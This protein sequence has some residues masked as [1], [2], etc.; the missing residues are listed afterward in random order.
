MLRWRV[1]SAL[2]GIPAL[3]YIAYLGGIYLAGL[4]GI[5]IFVGINEF[6]RLS[7]AGKLYPHRLV[8]GLGGLSFLIGAY[9]N[10]KGLISGDWLAPLLTAVIFMN[11]ALLVLVFPRYKLADL[12][13]SIFG[14]VYIGWLM[15]HLFLLR[16]LSAQ[17]FDYLLLTLVLTW[18]TD[19][20][21]YFA[22]LALGRHKLARQV[23]PNKTVEGAIGGIAASVLAAAAL[24]YYNPWLPLSL[25]LGLGFVVSVLG[26][27]GDLFES[28]LKRLG[29][30]KDSGQLIPGHGGVLDRFDSL[31]FT[32]PVVYYYLQWF[33]IG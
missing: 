3:L 27:L 19:T 26:Q 4:L 12:A 28:A 14:C 5:L 16:H 23:S 30:I 20:G 24:G 25:F 18:A 2:V 21:A 1:L 32:A 22:G 10:T 15:S 11:L 6:V 13:A 17:G 7:E 31:L 33:I 8:T 29:G 9:L